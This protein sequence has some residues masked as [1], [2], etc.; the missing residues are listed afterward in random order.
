[1][2]RGGGG[3]GWQ[4]KGAG[5]GAGAGTE[6][7]KWQMADSSG[8]SVWQASGWRYNIH[9]YI[10]IQMVL[11]LVERSLHRG[12]PVG[13]SYFVY[14]VSGN[15]GWSVSGQRYVPEVIEEGRGGVW[16]AST[17]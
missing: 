3:E 16:Q 13:Q 15:R 10:Y 7:G 6:A 8:H 14:I 12:R 5:A 1:M 17:I 11:L 9:I 2:I 4:A